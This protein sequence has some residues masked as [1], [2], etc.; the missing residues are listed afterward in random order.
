MTSH[1]A[2]SCQADRR[3]VSARSLR[4]Q[5]RRSERRD[6]HLR[7]II[8]III[9]LILTA[10]SCIP[11]LRAASPLEF[12]MPAENSDQESM[13]S[14]QFTSDDLEAMLN[15]LDAALNVLMW[16][17]KASRKRRNPV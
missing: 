8:V 3:D 5:K 17:N 13:L 6:K 11:S 4:S 12:K 7:V 16:V 9:K 1:V 14:Y 15:I 10:S 2:N